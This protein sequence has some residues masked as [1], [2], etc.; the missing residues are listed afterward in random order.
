MQAAFEPLKARLQA[1]GYTDVELFELIGNFVDLDPVIGKAM[2]F[3]SRDIL[4]EHDHNNTKVEYTAV[5][6]EV[7]RRVFYDVDAAAKYGTEHMPQHGAEKLKAMTDYLIHS[8][9]ADDT[10]TAAGCFAPSSTETH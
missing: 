4:T 1:K 10:A 6:T 5:I 7:Y 2:A 9:D 3:H 8:L